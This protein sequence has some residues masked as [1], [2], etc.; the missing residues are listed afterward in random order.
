MSQYAQ[1]RKKLAEQRQQKR[2][3]PK[4]IR[5]QLERIKA[6]IAARKAKDDQS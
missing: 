1:A 3:A 2:P 6:E 4:D 5:E